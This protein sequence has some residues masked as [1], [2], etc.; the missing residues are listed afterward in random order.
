MPTISQR[1]LIS[2]GGSSLLL[3]LPK[4]WVD[5]HGLKRGD[6]VEVITDG[7]LR[8]RLKRRK[9]SDLDENESDH[10]HY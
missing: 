4:A 6:K 2:L 9:R 5:Y 3:V 1:K 7:G 8:V 10:E